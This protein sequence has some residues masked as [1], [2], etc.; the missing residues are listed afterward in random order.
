MR[1]AVRLSAGSVRESCKETGTEGIFGKHRGFLFAWG[2]G[3]NG[4]AQRMDVRIFPA[5][6]GAVR[7]GSPGQD[8]DG[9][10]S[11][12]PVRRSGRGAPGGK[13][14]GR[15]RSGSGL[16][17]SPRRGCPQAFPVSCMKKQ[18]ARKQSAVYGFIFLSFL[19]WGAVPVR[20]PDG[21][22]RPFRTATYGWA[23][24]LP[25]R[26]RCSGRNGAYCAPWRE[27]W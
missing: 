9:G 8:A 10:G 21:L 17:V 26:C 25:F 12:F 7:L 24:F 3:G 6:H 4:T 5:V 23:P 22:P 18:T 19:P 20:C 1:K 27:A 11:R 2:K 15:V 16:S 13:E 14:S